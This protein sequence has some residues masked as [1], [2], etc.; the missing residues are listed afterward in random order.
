MI[1]RGIV[2]RV[3]PPGSQISPVGAGLFNL[4]FTFTA[5]H[6]ILNGADDSMHDVDENELH[7]C[8]FNGDGTCY[9]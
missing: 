5:V 9:M 8:F 3:S 2:G 4:E 6:Q 1:C 7:S